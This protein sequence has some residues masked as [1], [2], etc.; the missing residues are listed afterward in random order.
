[1]R[2]KFFK[3]AIIAFSLLA[4]SSFS[5]SAILPSVQYKKENIEEINEALNSNYLKST[6]FKD[7][8]NL[9]SN[10]HHSTKNIS[11]PQKFTVP[12]ET[13]NAIDMGDYPRGPIFPV[14]PLTLRPAD[15]R[16]KPRG[17][18]P[19]LYLEWMTAEVKEYLGSLGR[20][21][22][23]WDVSEFLRKN[24]PDFP[25][26]ELFW[27]ENKIIELLFPEDR[28]RPIDKETHEWIISRET[29]PKTKPIIYWKRYWKL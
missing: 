4:L 22:T 8:S 2:K 15:E 18:H 6:D 9:L 17:F 16:D 28:G 20:I 12:P 25:L 27:L 14:N 7:F 11:L 1:M 24:Y 21:T 10:V 3:S 13:Y 26:A 23:S 29:K 19:E 5:L